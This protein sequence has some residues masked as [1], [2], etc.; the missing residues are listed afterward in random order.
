MDMAVLDMPLI[1]RPARVVDAA[2][3]TRVA[4]NFLLRDLSR[5]G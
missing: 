5:R 3:L 2:R 1:P 4:L